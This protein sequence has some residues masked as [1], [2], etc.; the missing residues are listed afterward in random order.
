MRLKIVLEKEFRV[1]ERGKLSKR[2]KVRQDFLRSSV[3]IPTGESVMCIS[4]IGV[5]QLGSYP[6]QDLV[7][8]LS[9]LFGPLKQR[10]IEGCTITHQGFELLAG[11]RKTFQYTFKEGLLGM[12]VPIPSF[13]VV[14]AHF[15]NRIA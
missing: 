2:R 14:F 13:E 1:A 11:L 9:S 7:G 12:P 5:P 4:S 8:Y 10:F 3:H 6:I 15:I